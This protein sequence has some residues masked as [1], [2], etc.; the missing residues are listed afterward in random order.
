MQRY[1][2]FVLV[3]VSLSFFFSCNLNAAEKAPCQQHQCIAVVDAGST[4]SRLH[5]YSYD[6]DEN[7]TLIHLN[8]IWNKKTNPGISTI[9]ADPKKIDAYLTQ[10]FSDAPVSSIPLYFY[11]TAGMRLQSQSKQIVMYQALKNWFIKHQEWQL[12]E[13]KTITGKEEGIFDWLSMNYALG[14]FDN[15]STQ[16]PVGVMDF[17]GASVQIVFP[18]KNDSAMNQADKADVRVAGQDYQLFV[19]S[20][21]GLGQT[22]VTHQYLDSSSCFP[23]D[24]AL[25]DGENAQGNA[26]SCEK[27]VSN[28]MNG[29]HSVNRTVQPALEAN[30]VKQWYVMGGVVYM[31]NDKLFNYAGR[32]FTNQSLLNDSDRLVCHEDWEQLYQQYPKNDYLYS[33][34]L[35]SAYFYAL[36]VDG[37]GLPSDK[38][39]NY[40]DKDMDWTLGVVLYKNQFPDL[41]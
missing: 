22:E 14:T 35:L 23:N 8:E 9:D 11:A 4:G 20:F 7:N 10:L 27:D 18:V 21:L 17:G 3:F 28:L 36:M 5:I 24:Y 1:L 41:N 33:Y 2:K 31:A 12:I 16:K 26:N 13:A 37:Y 30:P 6:L 19:H 34:C 32:P 38:Q 15:R 29:V 39:I 40:L 25:P